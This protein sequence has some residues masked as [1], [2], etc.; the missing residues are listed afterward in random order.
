MQ[1]GP[2]PPM[3]SR[4]LLFSYITALTTSGY[5]DEAAVSNDIN[6]FSSGAYLFKCDSARDNGDVIQ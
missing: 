5:G 1:G 6:V 3:N 4:Y 2:G